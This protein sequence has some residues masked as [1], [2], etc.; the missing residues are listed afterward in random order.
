MPLAEKYLADLTEGNVYHIY[1]RT[2]NR[3]LLFRSDENRRF[4]LQRFTHYLSP[5]LG[6]Y[7]WCLLP[8]HFHFLI[9]V[10]SAEEIKKWLQ[11][12]KT[13]KPTEKIYLEENV[14]SALLLEKAFISFLRPIL[15]LITKCI[16]EP[17][18]FFTG[19]SKELKYPG[20]LIL[21]RL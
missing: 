12:F 6:T 15:W 9:E 21:P 14:S 19:H 17:G 8:N 2:N 5:Y 16:K 18:T 13:L 7:C 1:N 10:K 3:E 11:Q 20:I 4:F